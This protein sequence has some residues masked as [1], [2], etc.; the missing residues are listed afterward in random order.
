[1]TLIRHCFF[2]LGVSISISSLLL[3]STSIS[4][5]ALLQARTMLSTTRCGYYYSENSLIVPISHTSTARRDEQQRKKCKSYPTTRRKGIMTVSLESNIVGGENKESL[6]EG[7]NAESGALSK[8]KKEEGVSDE[9]TSIL[10]KVFDGLPFVELFKP[11]GMNKLPPMQVE[12]I[13]LLLYDVFLLV[14]LSI[15][16]SF[17]V[18]HRMNFD[19]IPA[20]FNEGSILAIFWIVSGLYHGIFLRSS[21]DGHYDNIYATDSN[22]EGGPK[23]AAI[24]ASNTFINAISLRLT[25]ALI[26][27]ILHHRQVGITPGEQLLPL[28]IGFGL[29]LMT[30]WRAIH[31][32]ITPRY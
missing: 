4:A 12:D 15:S 16:I 14:N 27:A 32:A 10:K 23:S 21:I 3:L 5:D 29:I 20:A 26:S 24:L 11:G 8:N 30:S 9:G 17:W 28:E 6:E 2:L 19:Y 31:S 22:G 7:K 18:T 13:N 25:F 1:M